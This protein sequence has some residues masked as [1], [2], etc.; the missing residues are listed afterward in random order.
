MSRDRTVVDMHGSIE[1]SEPNIS[2]FGVSPSSRVLADQGVALL[3]EC[4]F[5]SL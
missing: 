4:D 3:H 1:L 5:A 2:C